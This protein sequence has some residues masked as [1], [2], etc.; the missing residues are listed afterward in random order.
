MKLIKK[1]KKL[2]ITIFYKPIRMANFFHTKIPYLRKKSIFKRPIRFL[3]K[4]FKIYISKDVIFF[5]KKKFVLFTNRFFKK[6]F[7]L[8]E[9][10]Q[11]TIELTFKKVESFKK[12]TKLKTKKPKITYFFY[13]ISFIKDKLKAKTNFI[14]KPTFQK[15]KHP[16]FS[17]L[18]KNKFFFKSQNI[19]VR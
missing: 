11:K 16:T 2:F 13:K 17:F 5:L 3:F 4:I 12:T 19:R 1:I 18:R 10:V 14:K 8:I 6:L 7:F 9:K 15:I